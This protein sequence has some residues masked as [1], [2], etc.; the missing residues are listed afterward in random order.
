[1][2]RNTRNY[3]EIGEFG[4]DYLGYIE[5]KLEQERQYE[6]LHSLGYVSI[7][8]ILLSGIVLFI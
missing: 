3:F 1:M 8:V 4:E 6:L 2:K 5:D 7:L